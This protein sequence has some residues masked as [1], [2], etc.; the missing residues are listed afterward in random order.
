MGQSSSTGCGLF[1]WLLWGANIPPHGFGA[2][3]SWLA[4]TRGCPAPAPELPPL[5]ITAALLPVLEAPGE[6]LKVFFLF[7]SGGSCRG[8]PGTSVRYLVS[9]LTGR[10][11]EVREAA[12]GTLS[13]TGPCACLWLLPRKR[14]GA[15]PVCV[16]VITAK[17][18]G[19]LGEPGGTRFWEQT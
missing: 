3:I 6:D 1:G 16:C 10:G 7:S 14:A 9:L 11:T 5:G 13:Q 18:A 2:R 12:W 4:A 8:K 17:S 19:L 15:H